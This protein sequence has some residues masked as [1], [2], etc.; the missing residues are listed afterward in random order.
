CLGRS[1]ARRYAS[2]AEATRPILRNAG[3]VGKWLATDTVMKNDKAKV[4]PRQIQRR[5]VS[6]VLGDM[7]AIPAAVNPGP[8][9]RCRQDRKA[10]GLR[11][12]RSHR[13]E[14]VGAGVV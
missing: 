14:R 7:P 12:Q 3:A 5:T 6:F 2:T 11:V 1:W 10:T 4:S 8:D 9:G 13:G